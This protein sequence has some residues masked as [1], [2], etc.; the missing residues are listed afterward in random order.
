MHWN[1]YVQC[2]MHISSGAYAI[3]VKCISVLLVT[4]LIVLNL[5]EVYIM[6]VVSCACK[7]ISICG[8]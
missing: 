3:I 2:H 7:V 1:I 8:I 5:Y 6:T 4:L